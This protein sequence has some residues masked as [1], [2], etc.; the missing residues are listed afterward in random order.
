MTHTT[1]QDAPLPINPI[2]RSVQRAWLAFGA[3]MTFFGTFW[4]LSTL[5][6]LPDI[7]WLWVIAL[8][9]TGLVPLLITGLNKFSFVFCG[10]MF[11]CSAASVLRQTHLVRLNIAFPSLIIALGLLTLLSIVLPLR[12]PVWLEATRRP[13]AQPQTK[14]AEVTPTPN[15]A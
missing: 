6:Y 8:A 12:L 5:H 3:S 11:A 4:L 7:D 2:A 14:R 9:V 10:F 1:T 13:P 15:P